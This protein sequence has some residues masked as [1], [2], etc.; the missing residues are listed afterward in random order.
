MAAAYMASGDQTL[1]TTEVTALSVGSNATT[2]QRNEIYEMAFANIG[3]PAD[4][5]MV[6]VVR[7]CSALGTSTA[8]TPGPVSDSAER[9]AQAAVGDN[10]TGEPTF[11]AN[12]ILFEM[13][14]NAR[15]SYRWVLPPGG[16]IFTPA[17]VGAGIAALS[18]HATATTDWRVNAYWRE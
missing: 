11:V 12:T 16:A 18:L 7:R 1:T 15:A 2:A 13:G 17:T 10:H 8:I 4:L 9:A 5:V 14:V 6:H 3:T